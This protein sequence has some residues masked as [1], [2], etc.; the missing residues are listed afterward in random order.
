DVLDRAW[1]ARGRSLAWGGDLTGA[2]PA[3]S[4]D[5]YT[6]SMVHPQGDLEQPV[7]N[8]SDYNT[9][10]SRFGLGEYGSAFSAVQPRCSSYEPHDIGL[11]TAPA[12][13][14]A[15]RGA[16][17]GPS[18]YG[19]PTTSARRQTLTRQ[20]RSMDTMGPLETATD[21]GG[22]E[23][24]LAISTNFPMHQSS[25]LQSLYRA[26][27]S[28]PTSTNKNFWGNVGG[29]SHY[30][31]AG[32]GTSGR[33][34]GGLS[35]SAEYEQLKADYQASIEKLN[36]TMNS[37]KTFW[38]PELKRERQMR[39]EVER[40]LQTS[41]PGTAAISQDVAHLRMEIVAR[42]EKIRQLSAMVDEGQSSLSD[43][44]IREL[45][46]TVA[47][48]Q[49]MLRVKEQQMIGGIDPSGRFAL[50]NAL[51]IADEK[52]AR[53]TELQE[54]V[55]R[56]RLSRAGQPRDFTDKSITSHEM[57]TLR[58]K[59][60]RSE[61]ELSERKAELAQCQ[62]R[63]RHAEEQAADLRQHVQL[64][65]EQ[66]TNREQQHTLLQGD[67]DALRQK[68][69]GKN[70]QMEQRDQRIE[71]LEKELAAAKGE[72][73][74]K[75]EQIQQS[76][77]R[78]SQM[79]GRIDGLETS[80][81]D[82]EAELDKA[83]I[84]LLS[85]PDVIKEK[86]MKDK[87]ESM[88]LEKKRLQDHIDQLRRNSEKERLE[89]QETY[90]AELRQLRC[91]VENL[92]K[93]LADRDV[94]LESQ[95]E[96]IGDMDRELATSKQL[97]Q[98]AITDKGAEELHRE[99]ES[100]RGEID[101]LLKIVRQLEKE[102]TQL[103]SQCK[104]LQ[105]AIDRGGTEAS[106]GTLT[107]G[108]LTSVVPGSLLP[109]GI[110]AQ[111]KK[112]IEELEEALRESVSITAEREVHLSQQKHILHQVN[113]Q[114]SDAR[115]EN[116]ELRKR[117]AE[118]STGDRE[119]LMRALE[120]ERRQHIEQLLQLKQE[121]LM[122]AIAE[123]DAHLALLEKSRAPREEIDNVRRHKDSLMRKLKQEN[124]RR[125]M[126]VRPDS[127]A[128]VVQPGAATV[129]VGGPTPFISQ[130]SPRQGDVMA[131][132]GELDDAEGIWA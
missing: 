63:M 43:M 76:D 55:S 30:S 122:A 31:E 89:Q 78:T 13:A 34:Q 37:I 22:H 4:F 59:M 15:P 128:S 23:A 99:V 110:S 19:Y 127:A 33:M 121:A 108:D 126:V 125:A 52:Q 79:M 54:E 60:E 74:E 26:P 58:M 73:I 65:K 51:R 93:E 20:H 38:S 36:Q 11:A 95:N 115:R 44:R 39:R 3:R 80:L 86:E 66:I 113:Q 98:T 96:K 83:K 112:R 7:L 27:L 32:G 24:P 14:P 103:S 97:L 41:A 18:R 111:A 117:V 105:N 6:F 69:E 82:K 61:V 75:N 88:T 85:H 47:Q 129:A 8:P 94:L 114:L 131:M 104:Q 119:Q 120:A 91:N 45:E 123:K 70:Q 90:Q 28:N 46:D 2:I 124:E 42:D 87:I 102:N 101:K 62:T 118:G 106:S 84:R 29:M 56:L 5:G 49:E 77:H 71:R 92:Q 21:L 48:L 50:E 81:R 100:A 40:L 68:L 57:V 9:T 10:Q 130:P 107:K 16:S 17:A 116:A 1:P 53:I 35:L 67:V 132:S 25:G 109:G 12:P 64:L 72:V